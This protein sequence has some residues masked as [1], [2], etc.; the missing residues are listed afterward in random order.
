MLI[1]RV[2]PMSLGKILGVLYAIGG[3]FFGLIVSLVALAFPGFGSA[4]Q[5]Q[6]FP[7]SSLFLGVGAIVFLPIFYGAA[8]FLGG[9]IS[10][11]LYNGLA[12]IVGGVMIDVE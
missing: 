1:K 2:Q 7:G 12:K 10:A 4:P 9:L 8:G 3:L 5:Q 6:A 11:A